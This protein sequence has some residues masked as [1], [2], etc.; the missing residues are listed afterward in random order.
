MVPRDYARIYDVLRKI[1]HTGTDEDIAQRIIAVARKAAIPVDVVCHD[2][3]CTE[4]HQRRAHG[5]CAIVRDIIRTGRSALILP[6]A[7][8]ACESDG[9]DYLHVYDVLRKV[10]HAGTEDDIAERI[11]AAGPKAALRVDAICEDYPCSAPRD[12]VEWRQNRA[13]IISIIAGGAV[14]VGRA[15]C[16]MPDAVGVPCEPDGDGVAEDP[17]EDP[18][19]EVVAEVVA[20][21][22]AC[23][24]QGRIDAVEDILTDMKSAVGEVVAA[25][26]DLQEDESEDVRLHAFYALCHL[27]ANAEEVAPTLTEHLRGGDESL[28][29]M[30]LQAFYNCGR[31]VNAALVPDFL[32]VLTDPASDNHFRYMAARCLGFCGADAEPAVP[33]LARRLTDDDYFVRMH[34]AQSLAAIGRGAKPALPALVQAR[35]SDIHQDAVDALVR[36]GPDAQ[37]AVPSLIDGLM[38]GD[39]DRRNDDA[40]ILASIGPAA[41]EAVPALLEALPALHGSAFKSLKSIGVAAEE[42]APVL[43]GMT[44]SE[45]PDDRRFAAEAL[46]EIGAETDVAVAA[47]IDILGDDDISA[48]DFAARTLGKIGPR[49]ESAVSALSAVLKEGHLKHSRADAA[50]PGIIGPAARQAAPTLIEVRPVLLRGSA[51]AALKSI[52]VAAEEIAPV[53]V[54]MTDSEDPDYRRFA[55]G[56]LVEMGAET[57]VAV[58]ALIDILG[59]DDPFG[60]IFAAR[61]LGKIGP[62]AESAVPALTAALNDEDRHVRDAAEAALEKIVPVAAV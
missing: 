59:D 33:A 54:G 10:G 3:T 46:V 22:R 35:R 53:L 19:R 8:A 29:D 13:H 5:T 15:A 4:P 43:V 38:E 55:A 12:S 32:E 21:V 28:R 51:L 49:A 30:A 16:I 50:I 39:L 31:Y 47:L 41:K 34:S 27:G 58:A 6:D 42:I 36:L 48:R 9:G 40:A 2:Y 18:T 52:G 17:D 14:R 37:E 60:R 7:G 62:R 61:T 56:A 11:L 45:D 25:V 44:N 1:G 26:K 24:W 20:A 57:E 23:D